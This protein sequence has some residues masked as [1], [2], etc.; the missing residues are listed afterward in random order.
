[1]II[2]PQASGLIIA[3]RFRCTG[4]AAPLRASPAQVAG[5]A[6]ALLL[7]GCRE[8][9]RCKG[10]AGLPPHAWPGSA[11]I[12]SDCCAVLPACGRACCGACSPAWQPALCECYPCHASPSLFRASSKLSMPC[13]HL[14]IHQP[15]PKEVVASACA[16]VS[17]VFSLGHISFVRMGQQA[18]V[19]QK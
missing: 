1:M 5:S 3:M 14:P 11:Q 6:G 8:Q 18:S 13:P 2:K 10:G 16:L 7:C 17:H 12:L 9:Q 4:S 19:F 15:G